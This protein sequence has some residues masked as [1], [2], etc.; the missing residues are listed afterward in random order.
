[1]KKSTWLIVLLHLMYWAQPIIGFIVNFKSATTNNNWV[2]TFTLIGTPV[3]ITAFYIAYFFLFPLISKK[4]I[5]LFAVYGILTLLV[6]S[7]AAF[8]ILFSLKP[9][10]KEY[11]IPILA[12]SYTTRVLSSIFIACLLR[13]AVNWYTDIRYKKELEQKNLETSLALLRAQINPHFLFNTLNNIDVLIEKDPATAS[14]YLKKLSDILR[15][16]LYDSSAGDIPLQ[17]EITYI[18]QYLE[19]QKIRTANPDFVKFDVRGEMKY[20]QIAPMLFIPFIENA[21]K[22]CT[23]KKVNNGIMIAIISDGLTLTFE[24]NNAYEPQ[25]IEH[26]QQGGLGLEL[27]QNRLELLHHD[28]YNLDIEKTNERFTVKL[29]LYLHAN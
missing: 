10:E 1:M 23:N 12:F 9:N 18:E 2:W 21:F 7:I 24:C 25:L 6:I 13:G 16:T 19:L 26:R 8:L 17:Q 11:I 20:V 4:K 14:T 5:W 28:R 3:A 27:I 29:K 15:F 22:H